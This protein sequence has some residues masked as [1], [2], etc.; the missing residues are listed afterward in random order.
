M[1]GKAV[2]ALV[3]LLLAAL[4]TPAA[5]ALRSGHPVFDRAVQ[6]VVDKFYDAAA[7]GRFAEAVRRE[8]EDPRSPVSATGSAARVDTAIDTVLDSLHASHTGRFRPDG[9]DYFELADIFREAIGDDMRRL[10][11]PT[12]DVTYPGVGMIVKDVNGGLFVS[13]VYDGSPAARAGILTGDEILSIEGAPYREIASFAGKAGRTVAVKLRRHA[14]AEPA[15]VNVEVALL[16]PLPTFEQAIEKSVTVFERDGREIGYARLWTLAAPRSMS[17]IAEALAK[18][19]LRNIDGL[20]LDLRGRW[21]GGDP[22]AA[23]LFLGG[24]PT[25]RLIRRN[26][27]AILA[28]IRWH[29]PIVAIIDDNARSGLE[30]FAYALKEKGIALVGTRTAG[31]LLGGRAF[32]MP[33]ESLLEL[34][35]T[36]A[37]IGDGV[38]LEGNGVQP[39]IPVAFNLPYA[40]GRDP[41][42]EAAINEMQRILAREADDFPSPPGRAPAPN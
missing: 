6:L 19:P 38:R 41:Q 8:V 14:G 32:L 17:L 7:L 2:G 39:D 1:V 34:A 28:N 42:R 18:G 11:P 40:A 13:Q 31:A 5:E 16:R 15:S 33:D 21:G 30:V 3:F 4:P 35:V 22:D 10:F 24:T 12:G 36:D 9:I 25:F 37:V 23:E 29:G 27:A 20:V 26:G